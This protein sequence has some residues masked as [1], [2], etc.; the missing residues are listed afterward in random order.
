[1]SNYHVNKATFGA[2]LVLDPAIQLAL[3]RV[4]AA[5]KDGS[6]TTLSVTNP[7][8]N[9]AGL[10]NVD[11]LT[12]VLTF[13]L[14]S[15]QVVDLSKLSNRKGKSE[16]DSSKSGSLDVIA[17]NNDMNVDLKLASFK[18]VVLLG[19]GNDKVSG[20]GGSLAINAGG[21]NDTITTGSNSDTIVGGDG[22]D[23]I[24]SGSGKD[25]VKGG[26]GNDRIDS[27]RD[28]DTVYT[29]SGSDTILAGDGDDRIIIEAIAGDAQVIDGGKGS[30]DV[31]DLSGVTVSGAAQ[32]GAT[33]T[34]TLDSG[35]TVAV[36]GIER[37]MYDTN[38][39]TAGG[40][41]TVGLSTFL[42]DFTV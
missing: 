29:G 41:V 27:G 22:N 17:F 39:A 10:K 34:I 40:V 37:F 25:L 33:V 30:R 9:S 24:S 3:S 14:S 15:N 26:A 11:K 28:N 12:D 2:D 4:V 35:A 6:K 5:D 38:G 8:T 36:T 7:L 16:D 23:S 19:N 31:L 20:G 1:V 18:G 42:G 21:G 32:A 13:N